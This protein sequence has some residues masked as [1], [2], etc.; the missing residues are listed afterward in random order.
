MNHYVYYS[1]EEWGKGYIG[2]RS[3]NCSP[4]EDT[5]YMGSFHD[6]SFKPTEKIILQEFTTRESALEAEIRLHAFY[7]VDVNKHFANKAKQTSTR[8]VSCGPRS[9]EFKAKISSALR[10]RKLSKRHIE[11]V[12]KARSKKL[13][14][15]PLSE[16]H[17]K[18]LS[19][20]L[21]GRKIPNHGFKGRLTKQS[22]KVKLLHIETNEIYEFSSISKASE[23]TGIARANIY[24]MF[25]KPDLKNKGYRV[26][27]ETR[28]DAPPEPGLCALH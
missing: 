8:F 5:N 16:A 25:K 28:S 27:L 19:K 24:T 17:K 15:R 18:S 11:L 21:K 6:K 26:L 22:Q 4:R 13:K 14:G 10:G 23:F 12:S 1:Y 3:C 9:E 7:K 2:V 20:A